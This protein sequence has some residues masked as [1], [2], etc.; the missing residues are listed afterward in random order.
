MRPN[1]IADLFAGFSRDDSGCLVWTRGCF[2][3][4]YGA[5]HYQGRQWRTH[6]LVWTIERGDIAPGIEIL[7]RC[8]NPP[9]GEI[10]HLFAGTQLD[11]IADMYAKG[12][13]PAKGAYVR[14]DAHRTRRRELRLAVSAARY[15]TGVPRSGDNTQLPQRVPPSVPPGSP[16]AERTCAACGCLFLVPAVLAGHYRACSRECASALRAAANRNRASRPP[17]LRPSP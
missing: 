10:E 13:D 6:R 16:L 1:T 15:G 5:F 3:K 14:T 8:D 7:H 12:R 2:E 17:G 9:C 11:N 4:G